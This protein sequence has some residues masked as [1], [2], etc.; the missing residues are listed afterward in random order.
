MSIDTFKT[1][2]REFYEEPLPENI[3]YRD[4]DIPLDTGL[5]ISII[6]CRRAGKTTFL[7][8]Q[9]K[10]LMKRGISKEQ[11][12]FINFEDERIERTKEIFD[13][14]LLAHAELYPEINSSK[15]WYFFDEI[16]EI[17]GWEKFVRRV[18]ETKNKNIILTGS[19][20][21]LLS[22]EIATALRG[23]TISYEVF[24]FSFREF[25][26]FKGINPER[27]HTTKEKAI[28]RNNFNEY[29][30]QG[31]F[32]ETINQV[33]STKT[34]LFRSYLDV[35]IYR[36]LIERYKIRNHEAL[37]AFIT[38]RVAN[39]SKE[40]SIHKTYREMKSA[41]YE[42]SK[43]SLYKM[44]AWCEEIF[45]L[46][47]LKQYHESAIKQQNTGKKSYCIDNGMVVYTSFRT[48]E[49]KSNLAFSWSLRPH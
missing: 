15:C 12:V 31:G 22:R 18:H 46:F 4:I 11:I 1:I 14:L 9:V 38:K 3:I 25:L 28:I 7:K 45:L 36:D 40:N 13:D 47:N 49:D 42:I 10:E 26:Q 21:R 17:P 37:K 19:N 6:G 41:G 29:L 8:Q 16:Q 23:R 35:M 30:R 48:G 34:K 24:P 5:I 20:S 43:D 32:P 27:T 33:T 39:I 2:L 44:N